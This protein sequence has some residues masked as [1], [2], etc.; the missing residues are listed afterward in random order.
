ISY[1]LSAISYQT[2]SLHKPADIPYYP[3]QYLYQ[4]ADALGK[5]FCI[6]LYLSSRN[7]ETFT[8]VSL[9]PGLT[10]IRLIK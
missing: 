3:Y 7:F 6:A 4:S 10:P 2:H 9:T 8:A 1:Q 5:C